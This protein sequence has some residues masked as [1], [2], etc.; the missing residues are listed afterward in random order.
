ML[1]DPT[2]KAARY[3]GQHG[4][5]ERGAGG[6]LGGVVEG[7]E[8]RLR[9]RHVAAGADPPV[10]RRA[11]ARAGELALDERS[12]VG[13]AASV[14]GGV[15]M[16]GGRGGGAFN[17]PA[18]HGAHEAHGRRA[19]S[20]RVMDAPH[21]RGAPVLDAQHVEAPQ[22][23][24][25]VQ[26]LGEEIGHPSGE[27]RGLQRLRVLDDVPL[28]VEA[29]VGDPLGLGGR[30]A[31]APLQ[32]GRGIQPALDD[33][34]Q[35]PDGGRRRPERDDLAGMAGHGRALER[36]NRAVLGREWA[37]DGRGHSYCDRAAPPPP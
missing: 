22:R 13:S 33:G 17:L 1:L 3:G 19:V 16:G 14:V 27:R 23:P 7:I 21:Q 28:D 37:S 32:G 25:A 12:E 11:A 2:T 4:V 24:G 35:R 9:E 5:V 36:E 20:E 10:E 31:E 26:V 29:L 15:R 8:R 18:E 6:A 30:A 34:T